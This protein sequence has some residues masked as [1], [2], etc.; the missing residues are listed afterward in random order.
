MF[1]SVI[2]GLTF[3]VWK[4]EPR[5]MNLI[6]KECAHKSCYMAIWMEHRGQRQ[7]SQGTAY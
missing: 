3:Q 5:G 4:W 1:D 7:I 2:F 6:A